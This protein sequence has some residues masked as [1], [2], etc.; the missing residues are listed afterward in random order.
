MGCDTIELN[1]VKLYFACNMGYLWFEGNFY[2]FFTKV[3]LQ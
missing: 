3:K 2:A 1:L